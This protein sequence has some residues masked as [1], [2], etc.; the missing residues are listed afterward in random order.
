MLDMKLLREQPD[1]VKEALRNR[2]DDPE[3]VDRASAPNGSSP[4]LPIS[5]STP[6]VCSRASRGRA[7]MPLGGSC[8]SI[9]CRSC[10]GCSSVRSCARAVEEAA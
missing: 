6:M 5:S 2:N 1:R 4:V 9:I 10:C 8:W 3:S 7:S